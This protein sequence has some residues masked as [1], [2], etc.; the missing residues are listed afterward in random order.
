MDSHAYMGKIGSTPKFT[1]E[2]KDKIA[3]L[4]C[5]IG[6]DTTYLQRKYFTAAVSPLTV[7]GAAQR[8]IIRDVTAKCPD[9][10]ELK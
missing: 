6:I 3:L 9:N 1:A 2:I 4:E 8:L 7:H 5:D 10:T